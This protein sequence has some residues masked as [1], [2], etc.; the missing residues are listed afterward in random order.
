MAGPSV[1]HTPIVT[2]TMN[3]ALDQS[4]S[5]PLVEPDHKLRCGPSRFHPGGG[6]V[7][8]SRAI[9]RLGGDTTAL[10]TV[11]GSTGH[12]YEA[13]LHG[14]GIAGRGIPIGG[15]TRQNLTVQATAAA[16]EYRF[17]LQGPTLTEQEWTRCLGEVADL[18]SPGAY[19]VASGSLPP[20]VPDDFYGRIVRLATDAGARCVVDAS[21]SALHGAL[22][23]GVHLIKPSRRELGELVGA[24]LGTAGAQ[25]AASRELIDAGR[26]ELVALTLGGEGAM[27]VSAETVIRLPTPRVEV[28]STVGA[29]DSFLGAFVLR[30]AQGLSLPDA[31]RAAVAAG[32]ATAMLPGTEL[33][34][35]EDVRRL[36]AELIAEAEHDR[37]S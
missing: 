36:E 26:C 25:L 31:L 29:G 19:I 3:P 1:S 7:N 6:G 30:R 28:R 27:L 24:D 34:L 11:G 20:G 23:E 35:A 33:C 21:G 2:L 18:V 9:D 15:S 37:G 17:V 8:V 4:T 14:E 16:E 32:S 13:L 22:A 12:E 5:T 10:Y